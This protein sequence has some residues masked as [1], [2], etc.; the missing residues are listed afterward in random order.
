MWR[1]LRIG[2]SGLRSSCDSTARNSSL[3]RSASR[4]DCS[5][6][7]RSATASRS[8]A[9]ASFSSVMSTNEITTPAMTF[10]GVRYGCMRMRNQRP[11]STVLTA[12]STGVSVCSTSCTS[13][14]TPS[15][16]KR[17]AKSAS[18]RP[19]SPSAS[20][21]TDI[22]S[23]VKR[24]IRNCRSR[25]IV[26][27]RVLWNRFWR[28]PYRSS[29]SSTFLLSSALTVLS[30]SFTDCSSSCEVC[31]SS[32]E[33]WSS[34]FRDCSCS[35]EE[36]SASFAFSS[37]STVVCSR[38]RVFS[39]SASSC[40]YRSRVGGV[41]RR[42]SRYGRGACPLLEDDQVQLVWIL[43]VGG[44]GRTTRSSTRATP[45]TVTRDV[46]V[47]DR[48]GCL[49]ALW[50]TPASSDLQLRPDEVHQVRRRRPGLRRQVG[51]EVRAP[52]VADLPPA[53]DDHRGRRV[54]LED[55]VP[56]TLGGAPHLGRAAAGERRDAGAAARARPM[57]RGS[58]PG[59]AFAGAA[60]EQAGGL[61]HHL[62]EVELIALVD[63]LRP[64]RGAGTRR[65][66]AR[67]GR[68]R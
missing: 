64:C 16:S 60:P 48:A 51:A 32:F 2:A 65:A 25:K 4:S 31:S 15:A 37:S 44:S 41:E 54:L 43:L 29:S 23:G 9:S 42:A 35:F 67:S 19:M 6:R 10:D 18:G 57:S 66:G 22:A 55:D 52:V 8:A 20:R 26:A 45:S 14:G 11:D 56:R 50:R 12:R 17:A 39:S 62:E 46:P 63:D 59:P 34:S 24:A 33:E 36:W 53:I 27:I 47:G 49:A 38:P 7:S 28:S 58:D 68:A 61:V 40:R 13:P 1:L 21:K 30:S 3:R 5:A